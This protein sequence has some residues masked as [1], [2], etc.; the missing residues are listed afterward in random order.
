MN[1]CTNPSL[2]KAQNAISKSDALKYAFSEDIFMTSH[3]QVST[4]CGNSW[5]LWLSNRL[6][7]GIRLPE[8]NIHQNL[9]E[10][11]HPEVALLFRVC[12]Q[13]V[14]GD[15]ERVPALADKSLPVVFSLWPDSNQL[16]SVA[17]CTKFSVGRFYLTA[18]TIGQV[19]PSYGILPPLIIRI[20]PVRDAVSR[21]N[22]PSSMPGT[23]ATYVFKYS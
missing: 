17:S 4:W 8:A 1:I 16:K 20:G 12:R 3:K 21:E 10:F 6:V 5:S 19:Q 18:G 14:L 15:T 23:K 22:T 7:A 11:P 13:P 9:V 2:C